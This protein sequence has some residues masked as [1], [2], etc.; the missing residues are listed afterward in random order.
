MT[1]TYN[2][3]NYET[4]IY[5]RGNELCE[6]FTR[7]DSG[8]QLTEGSAVMEIGAFEMES[9]GDWLYRFSSTDLD[10]NTAEQVLAVR[11]QLEG[12]GV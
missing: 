1:Q 3:D 10:G 5:Q 7:A 12:G 6:L 2:S 9:L 4:L 8:A 11:C